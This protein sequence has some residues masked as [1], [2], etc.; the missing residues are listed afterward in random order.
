[1]TEEEQAVLKLNYAHESYNYCKN[2][3]DANVKLHEDII[4]N[5]KDVVYACD[6]AR[7]VVGANI[8][9]L[10]E[11]VI[12]YGDSWHIYHFAYYIANSNKEEL[13]KAMLKL[14]NEN[15][16]NEFIENIE[17]SQELKELTIFM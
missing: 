15:W 13:F 9:R 17:L 14:G 8:E 10:Q 1:M 7:Y 6:F 3:K 2:N 4:V 5:N 12:N 11:V 16:I